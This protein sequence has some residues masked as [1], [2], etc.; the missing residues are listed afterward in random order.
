MKGG[1]EPAQG[2]RGA[3]PP[4]TT[5]P[6]PGNETAPGSLVAAGGESQPGAG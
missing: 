2:A 1:G 5:P 4:A 6:A 3:A